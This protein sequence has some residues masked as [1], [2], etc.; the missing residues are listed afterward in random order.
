[1]ESILVTRLASS[2]LSKNWSKSA[3]PS[4]PGVHAGTVIRAEEVKKHIRAAKQ[5]RLSEVENHSVET[6]PNRPQSSIPPVAPVCSPQLGPGRRPQYQTADGAANLTQ[7]E[8]RIVRN[9]STLNDATN[10]PGLIFGSLRIRK[11]RAD[12]KIPSAEI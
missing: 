6:S 3:T 8:T 1:M 11:L 4:F 9:P 2:L 10:S 7:L 5:G 12:G